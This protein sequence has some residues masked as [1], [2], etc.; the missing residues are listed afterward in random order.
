MMGI[1]RY[2]PTA[3]Y[4]F[5][6][7]LMAP[8]VLACEA[9]LNLNSAPNFVDRGMLG[10]STEYFQRVYSGD[11]MSFSTIVFPSQALPDTKK[12]L[13]DTAKSMVSSVSKRVKK[14]KPT[15]QVLNQDL[16]PKLDKRLA[17]LSYIKYGTDGAVNV[18]AAG[19]I[20]NKNCWS[21]LRFTALE[22]ETR[23]VALNQFAS[24]I[25]STNVE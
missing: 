5:Y 23:D 16:L 22:K 17:F 2:W 15:V 12:L 19:L 11:D 20:Q 13:Q 21:I 1:F 8:A 18:E 4:V 10:G 9:V 3:L 14:S 6:L 25:R 24:L 7:C